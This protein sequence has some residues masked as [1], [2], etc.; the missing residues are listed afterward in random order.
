MN[1]KVLEGVRVVDLTTAYS[2]PFATMQLADFGAEVIKVENAATGDP[3]RTWN[4][5]YKGWSVQFFNMNRNKKSITLNLKTD[6]GKQILFDLVKTADVVVENFR[7]GVMKRLGIDYEVLRAIKPDIIMASLSGYGQTG[8]YAQRGAYS[9]LAEALSGVMS[10][11]GYPDGKPTG[12]GVAFGDSIGG[13]FTIV[14]AKR[15][16]IVSTQKSHQGP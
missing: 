1:N 13:L 8:P 3:A 11:T 6:E 7:P 9:N 2:A 4:P 5:I 10:V 15:L 16:T 14:V 12:S